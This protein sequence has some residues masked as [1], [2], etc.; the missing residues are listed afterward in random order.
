MPAF[1]TKK[2]PALLQ[3]GADGKGLRSVHI[4]EASQASGQIYGY[5]AKTPRELT[6]GGFSLWAGCILLSV[7]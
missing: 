1:E 2:A 6:G 3:A 4:I 5:K 7:L